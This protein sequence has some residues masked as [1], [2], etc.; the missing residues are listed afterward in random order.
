MNT[1]P[2]TTQPDASSKQQIKQ[3]Y[4]PKYQQTGLPPHPA[5]PIRRKTNKISAQISPYRKLTQTTG[6][7]LVG[8]KPKRRKNLTVNPAKRRPQTE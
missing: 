7:T 2:G 4:K 8:Q 5:L 1:R 6:Q 3:K